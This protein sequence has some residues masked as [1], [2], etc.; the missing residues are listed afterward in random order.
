MG[1]FSIDA[2]SMNESIN[3]TH[4]QAFRI[5]F[6]FSHLHFKRAS[7]TQVLVRQPTIGSASFC[8]G[9]SFY[10]GRHIAKNSN[11]THNQAFRIEFLFSHLHFKRASSVQVLVRQP[12]IGSASFCFGRSFYPG[13]RIAKNLK[14]HCEGNKLS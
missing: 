2:T 14:H 11:R 9:R 7:S 4:N 13:R 8:V 6:L 10:P 12:T 1:V 5:E 3:R